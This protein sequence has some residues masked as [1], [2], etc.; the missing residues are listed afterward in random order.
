MVPVLL[1]VPFGFDIDLFKSS[2]VNLTSNDNLDMSAAKS[3]SERGLVRISRVTIISIRAQSSLGLLDFFALV[4][5]YYRY[6][7]DL[8]TTT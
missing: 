4:L 3:K 1:K 8:R 7:S 5:R 6:L 2:S